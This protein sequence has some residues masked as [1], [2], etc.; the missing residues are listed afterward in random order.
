[1]FDMSF[2]DALHLFQVDGSTALHVAARKGRHSAVLALLGAGSN[3]AAED[4][5]CNNAVTR[6]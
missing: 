5:R 4:V 6:S 2:E 1:M 3:I